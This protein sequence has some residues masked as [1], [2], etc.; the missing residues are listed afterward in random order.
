MISRLLNKIRREWRRATKVPYLRDPRYPAYWFDRLLGGKPARIV[1][2]GS[3]DGKTGDPLHELLLRHRSWSGLFVEPIPYIF[4]RLKNNYPNEDRFRFANVAINEGER[5][6][7]YHV[8][9]AAKVAHPEL[10]EWY[11][12]LGSFNRAHLE[13]HLD[14]KLVPFIESL[15]V[16]GRT[17]PELLRSQAVESIDILHIDCEGYDWRVLSQLDLERFQPTFILFEYHH[18]IPEEAAAARTFLAR[19]YVVHQ[20]G[21]DYLAVHRRTDGA[22]LAG[23]ARKMTVV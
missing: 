18:L 12:Q 3:N 1:Q 19:D 16:T 8:T 11:D 2:I 23:L 10:P 4:E 21:I 13:N 9:A 22:E 15:E 7:F 6:P 5:M 20:T 14:G 17:L